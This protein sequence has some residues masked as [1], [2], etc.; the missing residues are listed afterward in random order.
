[1][2]NKQ[3]LTDQIAGL[4]VKGKGLRV[5]EAIFLKLQ[6]I[7]ETI[8]KTKQEKTKTTADLEAA[9]ADKKALVE[10]KNTAVSASFSKIIEKMNEILPDGQAAI[11]LDD[12]LFLGWELDNVYTPYNG[13]SGGQKQIFDAAL[14][15]VLDAN[16]ICIE[17]AELDPDHMMA[18]ME[19]MTEVDKQVL[20]STRSMPRD[21]QH[22]ASYIVP[23]GFVVVAV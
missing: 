3:I 1:M 16:I 6:G 4:T 17:S 5:D 7:N 23:D 13:L 9:K 10:K 14:G 18:L 20:I 19:D 2:D 12:G 21:E 8:E 11:N 15:Y 22:P